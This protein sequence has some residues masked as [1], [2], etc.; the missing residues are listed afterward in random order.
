MARTFKLDDLHPA[1]DGGT[2]YSTH[3]AKFRQ[4][5]T[6]PKT[7]HLFMSAERQVSGT[8]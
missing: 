1:L 7:C 4:P 8:G 3:N 6:L 5:C 2:A